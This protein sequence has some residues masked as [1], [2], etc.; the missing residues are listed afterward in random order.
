MD[1]R[2]SAMPQ[3]T[4]S[5][6]H[7][8]PGADTLFVGSCQNWHRC[9]TGA[10]TTSQESDG[11][12]RLKPIISEFKFDKIST[13]YSVQTNLSVEQ[14]CYAA[15]QCTPIWYREPASVYW[16]YGSWTIITKQRKPYCTSAA[17][18]SFNTMT[19]A[20]YISTDNNWFLSRGYSC[21]ELIWR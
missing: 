13:H 5:G 19:P 9:A 10:S 12:W 16:C 17:S 14:Q 11:F 7:S 18:T 3:R 15:A 20:P 6:P 21:P 8:N 2:K 4:G 1:S